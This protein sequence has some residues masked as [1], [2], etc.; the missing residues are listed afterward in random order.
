MA[1]EN[2]SMRIGA[3]RIHPYEPPPR[4]TR[5]RTS[6]RP[7]VHPLRDVT[8]RGCGAKFQTHQANRFYCSEECSLLV[9]FA[10]TG[11]CPLCKAGSRFVSSPWANNDEFIAQHF[12]CRRT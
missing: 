7:V 10:R 12:D 8:C 5:Q 6:R 9:M 3:F 2:E 11:R 4:K 1:E